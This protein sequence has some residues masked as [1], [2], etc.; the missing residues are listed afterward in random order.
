MS[1]PFHRVAMDAA[2]AFLNVRPLG[3][4]PQPEK[5][6]RGALICAGSQHNFVTCP[7][8]RIASCGIHCHFGPLSIRM[9]SSTGI[10]PR[11]RN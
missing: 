2:I 6:T 7:E 10:S 5:D 1:K 9:F 8:C 3:V 11:A 4:V